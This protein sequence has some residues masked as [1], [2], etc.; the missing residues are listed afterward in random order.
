MEQRNDTKGLG[1]LVASVFRV[2]WVLS[3]I[4]PLLWFAF[5]V[6]SMISI[7]RRDPRASK[8]EDWGIFLLWPSRSTLDRV[9]GER[10]AGRNDRTAGDPSPLRRKPIPERVRHAVWRR[11]QGRCVQCGSQERLEFDHIIP[12][13][14]GGSDTE[15][16]LQLLCEACNRTKG[17]SI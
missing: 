3:G 2:V 8:I 7:L 16:N 11:D 4:G 9:R 17:A 15:R 13:S 12:V 6:A 5:L 14:K 1:W 10:E